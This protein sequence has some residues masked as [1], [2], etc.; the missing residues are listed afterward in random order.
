MAPRQPP[1][2]KVQTILLT[3]RYHVQADGDTPATK[4]PTPAEGDHGAIDVHAKAEGGN[5]Q[6]P[7]V[8]ESGPCVWKGGE[9]AAHDAAAARARVHEPLQKRLPRHEAATALPLCYTRVYASRCRY[10]GAERVCAATR[11]AQ[12]DVNAS[13]SRRHARAVAL[14]HEG[15]ACYANSADSKR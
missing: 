13:V 5:E 14:S 4:P 9:G 15:R 1:Y 8:P 10:D 3:T 11:H 2:V 6:I 7:S 12:R